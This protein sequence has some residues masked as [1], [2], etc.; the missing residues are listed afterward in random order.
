MNFTNSMKAVEYLFFIFSTLFACQN[1]NASSGF[2][3]GVPNKGNTSDDCYPSNC[4]SSSNVICLTNVTPP[5]NHPICSEEK[6][7]KVY[8]VESYKVKSKNFTNFMN[9]EHFD[10]L[11]ATL[12]KLKDDKLPDNS[13][14]VFET[15]IYIGAYFANKSTAS[16]Y[17]G[18]GFDP[19]GVKNDFANSF[20][21]QTINYNYGGG[22]GQPD[23]IA[24]A[25]NVNHGD[26][27]FDQTDMP[28]KMKYNPGIIIG[29]HT[30]YGFTKK[31]A[32]I[33]NVS[34]TRLTVTGDFTIT[35]NTTP[36]GNTQPGYINAPTFAITGGEQ[37]VLFQMGY[38]R[39]LG[40]NERINFFIEGGAELDMAKLI[41]NQ[42]TINNLQIDLT[43]YY[44]YPQWNVFR[45]KHLSGVGLGAFGG[46]G[47]NLSVNPKCNIQLVYN[48]S[49]EKIN[50]GINTK[51]KLQNTIGLRIYYII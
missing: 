37:R 26:W 35:L 50:I 38:R 48:P 3:P 33:L 9:F 6:S 46:L 42:L 41:K 24:Q 30:K 49:Y 47:L 12:Y 13:W 45:A 31:D 7:Y 29:I 1:T 40:N 20:M 5:L 18:Y 15:G 36:V 44:S 34:G 32:L 28:L 51:I 10:K 21:N 2:I 16:I 39:I 8:K 23:L 22:N 4:D 17:D 25:L 11:S 27:S 14:T 43:T 19:N